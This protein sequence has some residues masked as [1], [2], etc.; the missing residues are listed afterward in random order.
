MPVKAAVK[1]PT[2]Q[3]RSSLGKAV[4]AKTVNSIQTKPE[5]P[6]SKTAKGIYGERHRVAYPQD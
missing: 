5:N 6:F 3:N 4:K 1:A 2:G